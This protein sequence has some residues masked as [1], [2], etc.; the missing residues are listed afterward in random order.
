MTDYEFSARVVQ[1]KI[2][3]PRA[4]FLAEQIIDS[5]GD[6]PVLRSPEISVTPFERAV[7]YGLKSR[8]SCDGNQQLA[9]HLALD[10]SIEQW[11]DV[12]AE[13]GL[14]HKIHTSQLT[15]WEYAE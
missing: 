6:N 13:A 2:D 15:V 9:V 10:A 3:H 4:L 14:E 12:L 1:R 8:V 5:L 11:Q 7:S